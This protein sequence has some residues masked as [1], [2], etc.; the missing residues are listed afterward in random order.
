MMFSAGL[1]LL[2]DAGVGASFDPYNLLAST[3]ITGTVIALLI[4]G[5]LRTESEVKRLV[6]ENERKDVV[7]KQKDEQ[8]VSLQAGIVDQAIPVLTRSTSLLE[9]LAESGLTD[10]R[11]GA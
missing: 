10:R 5:K 3:G 8:I 9:K 11:R 6:S 7:I 2:A 1:R 4:S